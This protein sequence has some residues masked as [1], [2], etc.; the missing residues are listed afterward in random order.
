M[1]GKGDTAVR[2]LALAG[3]IISD[4]VLSYS[5]LR[6][7][8]DHIGFASWATWLYPVG[9]DALI[10][11]ASRTWQDA[12]LKDSTRQFAKRV[13]LLAIVFGMAGFVAEFA[14]HGFSAVA[15]ALFIPA[16]LAAA[17]ILTSRAAADRKANAT[18]TQNESVSDDAGRVKEPVVDD[19]PA[20]DDG[21]DWGTHPADV[22][23]FRSYAD[24]MLD[25]IRDDAPADD[26]PVRTFVNTEPVTITTPPAPGVTN[27][28][29][30]ASH[31]GSARVPVK[32]VTADPIAFTPG[33]VTINTD[34]EGQGEVDESTTTSDE[35]RAWIN[36]QLDNGVDVR[37][38]DVDAQF[39]NSSR[40]GAR[41]VRM[42]KTERET[43]TQDKK[44]TE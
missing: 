15:F 18:Q 31:N 23:P 27:V 41:L 22:E 26:A 33:A 29:L 6:D 25:E 21:D 1:A 35:K 16:S 7:R 36:T 37:G 34:G 2:R 4:A 32:L 13:T 43:R 3:V 44:E 28:E 40:N 38:R 39:P 11:G 20:I 19:A 12:D 9:L 10:V 8:A 17:L 30:F 42:V 14:P 24:R 5:I